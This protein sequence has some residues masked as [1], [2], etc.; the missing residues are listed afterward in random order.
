VGGEKGHRGIREQ[1]LRCC[2]ERVYATG[3]K[4]KFCG[5]V[6][7]FIY[8][9]GKRVP[10]NSTEALKWYR[11]ASDQGDPAA[12]FILGAMYD[13]GDGVSQDYKEVVKWYRLAVVRGFPTRS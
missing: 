3:K 8:H 13:K 2:S 7:G 9:E 10:Q 12:Q 11:L 1:R 6:E 5:A 4:G